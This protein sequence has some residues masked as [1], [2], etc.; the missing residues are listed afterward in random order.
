[1]KT[2][3]SI[4]AGPGIGIETAAQFAQQG[5]RVILSARSLDK[6]SALTEDLRAQGFEAEARGVDVEDSQALVDLIREVEEQYGALD[7]LHYN[8]AV[9]RNATVADQPRETFV[10]DL[11][12]N[13]GGALVAIQAAEPAMAARGEGTILLTGGGFALH[14]HPEYLSISI[15]KAGVRALVLGAFEAFRAKGI[16]LATVTVAGFVSPG[17]NTKAIGRLFWDVHAQPQ[18]AWTAEEVYTPAG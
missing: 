14:P 5:F 4:G 3:L 15:G 1:M 18:D 9:I 13:I 6:V 17:E 7:V 16:H 2:F 8:A 10:S 11:I 12:T